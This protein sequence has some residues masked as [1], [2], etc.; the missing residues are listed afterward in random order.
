MSAL[1]A[2]IFKSA[3][4]VLVLGLVTTQAAQAGFTTYQS[5]PWGGEEDL[6]TI[7]DDLYGL[8]N[9]ERV[10]DYGTSVTDQ[11][12]HNTGSGSIAARAKFAALDHDFGFV[13]G[14]T[15]TEFTSLMGLGGMGYIDDS[16]AAELSVADTGEHFRFALNPGRDSMWRSTHA[17]NADTFDHMITWRVVG[18][19][20]GFGDNVVGAYILAWEDMSGG[21]DLDYQDLIVE[22]RG[23]EPV[24]EP[25]SMAL[26]GLGILG[27]GAARRIRRRKRPIA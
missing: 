19:G 20:G 14:S 16:P 23:I 25:T 22:V 3:T 27:V 26:F 5:N 10:H 4:A 6:D 15:G 8:D 12:W 2:T 1:R 18:N 21:G 9:L 11:I 24:P 13:S 17:E 7:L